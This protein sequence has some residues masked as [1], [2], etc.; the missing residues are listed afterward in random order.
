MG[1]VLILFINGH[2]PYPTAS[3]S[4]ALWE[5]ISFSGVSCF[6]TTSVPVILTTSVPVIFFQGKVHFNII[7]P[8]LPAAT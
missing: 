5:A 7:N 6:L 3:T 4:E 1:T 2:L 8:E